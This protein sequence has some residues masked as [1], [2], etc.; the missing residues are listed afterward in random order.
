MGPDCIIFFQSPAATMPL[1]GS[2]SLPAPHSQVNPMQSFKF[3][4]QDFAQ[5][6]PELSL[7]N[8][9]LTH[10][11]E[12]K[13]TIWPFPFMKAGIKCYFSQLLSHTEVSLFQNSVE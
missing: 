7:S 1:S 3:V 13:K 2:K 12:L 11:L 6:G 9:L 8:L 10:I 5:N 4:T